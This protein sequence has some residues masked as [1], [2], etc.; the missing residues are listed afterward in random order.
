[1]RLS[2]SNRNKSLIL[3]AVLILTVLN[4]VLIF[5]SRSQVDQFAQNNSTYDYVI[6]MDGTTV[7]ARNGTTGAIDYASNDASYVINSAITQGNNIYIK[8]GTYT[9]TSDIVMYNKKN[10]Q[11]VSDGAIINATGH[12][13]AV[14]GDTYVDSQCNLL[15]SMD[16]INGT[17]W[18]EN[19]FKTTI[20]DMTLE[21]SRVALELASNDSWSE[22]TTIESTHFLKC[23]QSI[24]FSA[25]T[26]VNGT[27]SYAN[28]EIDRCYFNL[29]DNS[30]GVTVEDGAQFS[31]GL[32]QNVR[33]WLGENGE[34]QNQTGILM[35]GT[36]SQT[37]LTSVG[38]ESFIQNGTQPEQIY[39]IN[40]DTTNINYSAPILAGGNSFLGTYTARVYNPN[41]KLI[42]GFGGLFTQKNVPVIVGTN[43]TFGPLQYVDDYP[44]TMADFEA[45]IHVTGYFSPN[46]TVTV[47]FVFEFIDH[48]TSEGINKTFTGKSDVWLTEE[49]V[50]SQFP[51]QNV[52]WT[53]IVTAKTSA[54]E[55]DVAVSLDVYG[56]AT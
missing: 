19:S 49:D 51:S 34:H 45:Q 8:Q 42:Y 1:M 5:V 44:L 22:G 40:I 9:L 20:T 33:M 46:E 52:L 14:K 32:M 7:K 21:N 16:V 25:P 55:S 12:R 17:V 11:I 38:F 3:I 41:G 26:G 53:V 35:R 30:V 18:I 29:I 54:T 28:T 36:M 15:S 6:F 37:M 43:D 39:A 48:S 56:A 47:R 50:V 2:L 27:G 31:N 13:I 24:V 23:T 10:A 4:T